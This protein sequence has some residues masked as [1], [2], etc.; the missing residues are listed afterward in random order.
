LAGIL[1]EQ[2]VPPG[3]IVVMPNGVRREFG[4]GGDGVAFRRKLGLPA[5]A[6]VAGFIGWFR[7]WHGLE[8]LLEVAASSAWR[9]ARIHLVLGGAN[10]EAGDL[11]AAVLALA[12]DGELRARLG[13]AA[14]A[15]LLERGY[16]WEENARRVEELVASAR[17]R[18]AVAAAV[19]SEEATPC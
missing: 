4:T 8:R 13:E 17:R 5:D 15:R 1:E 16:L 11:G 7:A 14:R 18:P 3:K 9:E 2:G 6:V 19:P 12:G 10:P